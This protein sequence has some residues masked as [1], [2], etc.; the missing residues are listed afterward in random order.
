[1]QETHLPDESALQTQLVSA[2]EALDRHVGD[3]QA[4]DDELEAFAAE[5]ERYTALG[6][7]C[8]GLEHLDTLGASALFWGETPA[9][10]V[11]AHMRE[12]AGQLDGFEKQIHEIES[13]RNKVLDELE[14][15]EADAEIIEDDLFELERIKEERKLEWVVEREVESFPTRELLMPWARG[16][17]DDQRFRKNLAIALLASLFLSVVFPLIPLPLLD[18]W[19][20][21]EVPE[22][23]TR[24]IREV[25]PLPPVQQPTR[26]EQ[27]KEEEQKLAKESK[28]DATPKKSPDPAPA[29]KGILAF[30]EKFS[31]LADAT[32][33]ARLGSQARIRNPGEAAAGRPQRSLVTTNGPGASGG[34][35]IGKLSRNVGSGGDGIEGVDIA[36]A[37]SSI[38][39]IGVGSDRPLSDGPG[40]SRT[41]E[42]IQIVFDRHKAQLYRLYNR[43]LRKNPTLQGQIVLR[44]TIEP[45]GSVSASAVQSSDMDAPRL[46]AQVAGR[47]KGFDFGA[48]DG[49]PA[50]TILYPI[51]FLP[52]S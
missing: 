27:K 37:T 32:T 24:L 23:L 45:D 18:P 11:E 12:A 43:E 10:Q 47:V 8:R 46:S 14:R 4:I 38:S 25:E 41:D 49:I 5:R 16:G 13:R 26:P 42:E 36:R 28:P 48:K 6:E 20:A 17:E 15:A 2:R 29:S 33:S 31:S 50:I 51:D 1:M 3:L 19:A 30:R 44:I 7:V 21:E 22:R 40:L 39:A 52:A 9:H 35:D 34:I